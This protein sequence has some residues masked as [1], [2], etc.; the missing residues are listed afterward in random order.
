MIN[1]TAFTILF[2]T[3]YFSEVGGILIKNLMQIGIKFPDVLSFEHFQ[4]QWR[5]DVLQWGFLQTLV[6]FKSFLF[7]IQVAAQWAFY[8]ERFSCKVI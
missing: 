6:Y 4:T 5:A 3:F 2:C 1:R 7:L 8:F